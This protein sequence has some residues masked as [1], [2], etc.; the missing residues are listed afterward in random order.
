MNSELAKEVVNKIIED[1]DDNDVFDN[2]FLD[3]F[4]FKTRMYKVTLGM[5]PKKLYDNI[6]DIV[7][8]ICDDIIDDNLKITINSLMKRGV[9]HENKD[10]NGRITYSL[11]ED[12]LFDFLIKK[13]L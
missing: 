2:A 5:T 4:K 1:L 13:S 11:D 9:I 10:S 6:D 8:R 7:L 12:F 3:K